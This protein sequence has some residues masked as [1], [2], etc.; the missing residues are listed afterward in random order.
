MPMKIRAYANCDDALIVWKPDRKIDDCLGFALF[1]ERNGKVECVPTWVG[2][3]GDWAKPGTQKPSTQWPIQKFM[4]TDYLADQGDVMR[5]RVVPMR[6]TRADLKEDAEGASEWSEPVEVSPSAGAGTAAFFNRGVVASQWLARRLKY[7]PRKEQ[8]AK[9]KEI[10]S[11]PNAKTRRFLAGAV[12]EEM[13]SLLKE[14]R[15]TGGS[16][17]CALYELNDPEL[18]E[19]LKS[20]GERANVILANGSA[21]KQ[22]DDEN[23]KGREALKCCVTLHNRMVGGGRLAHNKFLVLCAP[24]GR[25]R[26]VW[27]GSTNWT[28]TGLCTQANNGIIF[29]NPS[30]ASWFKEQ[31]EKLKRAGDEFPKWLVDADSQEQ[32]MPLDPGKIALWFTP[33]RAQKDLAHARAL[34]REA[35]NG[36]LFLMFN[37][38]PKG[39]LLNEILD[40]RDSRLYIHGVVNQD[41]GGTKNPLITMYHRGEEVRPNIDVILPEAIDQRLSFWQPELKQYSIAMVHSK[42]I[43]IDPFGDRPVVMTGSHNMGPKASSKNDDNLAIIEGIGTLA[44]DYAVNIISIYNQYRWRYKLMETRRKKAWMSLIPDDTWQNGYFKEEKLREIKFWLGE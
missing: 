33:V 6:G 3:P 17:Y 44:A 24:D 13:L 19:A 32:G 27:T 40:L 16:I 8:K 38:G 30:V 25:P 15:E 2:F 11:D 18:I 43:V 1:R 35:R 9:L 22:G 31:W 29:D 41:P 10:I 23:K 39:T 42:V 4:W 26:K 37:P 12:R 20:L 14:A 5:Y 28:I 36:I 7:V 21:K 34:I